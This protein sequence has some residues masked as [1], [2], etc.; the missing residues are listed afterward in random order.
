MTQYKNAK[1]YKVVNDI[2]DKICIGSTCQELSKR[3]GVHRCPSTTSTLAKHMLAIGVE[4]FHIVL[5]ESYP[6]DS[7]PELYKRQRY[8]MEQIKCELNT[9]APSRTGDGYIKKMD[10]IKQREERR[11]EFEQR[12]KEKHEKYPY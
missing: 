9:N 11:K 4:N 1:I 3:M 2:D 6:C 7:K 10:K 8:W 5:I 12:I